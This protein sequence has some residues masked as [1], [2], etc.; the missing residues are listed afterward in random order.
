MPLQ[1]L[2]ILD[3]GCGGGILSESL[4]AL[5]GRVTGIDASDMSITV[6]RDHARRRQSKNTYLNTPIPVSYTHL[7]AHET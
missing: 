7:R 6:A 4:E 1:G 5:G 2:S 3:V